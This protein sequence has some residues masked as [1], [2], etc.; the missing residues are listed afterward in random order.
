MAC[1]LGAGCSDGSTT[2]QPQASFVP[3]D[4]AE[5]VDIVGLDL[6]PC[7]K[8][9]LDGYPAN[10]ARPSADYYQG[11]WCTRLDDSRVYVWV[12]ARQLTAEAP[13][14]TDEL[15][16]TLDAEQLTLDLAAQGYQRVC[17]EV[18]PGGPVNVGV[19]KP[20]NPLQIRVAAL[21]Q[22]SSGAALQGGP[23]PV[24]ALVVGPATRNPKVPEDLPAPECPVVGTAQP[25]VVNGVTGSP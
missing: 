20:G 21:D 8:L 22:P 5:P 3:G 19:E 18:T 17:G 14:D 4:A 7:T 16:V 13:P 12:Y 10:L 11:P 6:Q 25:M 1:L 2:A 23:P 24:L 9:E 15:D